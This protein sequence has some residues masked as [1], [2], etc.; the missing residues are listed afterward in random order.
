MENIKQKYLQLCDTPS[1]INEHLPTLFEYTSKCSSVLELGVRGC[2]SSYA[3]ASGL[4]S[5][6][7]E[8]TGSKLL[9]LNDV[10][11]C[12][13]AELLNYSEK[14]KDILNYLYF[15]KNNLIDLNKTNDNKLIISNLLKRLKKIISL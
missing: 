11:E 15:A 5:E 3:F 6:D 13:I 7:N 12:N 8:N 9:V 2:V 1:D 4:I 14:I 10:S